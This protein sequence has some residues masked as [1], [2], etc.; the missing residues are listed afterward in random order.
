MFKIFEIKEGKFTAFPQLSSKKIKGFFIISFV[1]AI[2]SLFSGWLNISEKQLWKYYQLLLEQLNLKHELP[3]LKNNQDKLDARVE[4]AVDR[5]LAE[6]T[7]E[8]DRIIAEADKTKY[9]PRYVD[10]VNDETVC[11]TD[12]CK[13]LA[14]PMRICAPWVD[15]CPKE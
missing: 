4:L 2:I 11:Y 15:D 5:A 8:Y 6:V 13:T 14:P 12:E 10:G 7:P 9:K 3:E 1:I